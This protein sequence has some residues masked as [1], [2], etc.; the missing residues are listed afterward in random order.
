MRR[1]CLSGA[2]VIAV[3]CGPEP[4]EHG[5]VS[6]ILRNATAKQATFYVSGGGREASGE[7]YETHWL[8]AGH[9]V[10]LPEAMAGPRGAR[11]VLGALVVAEGLHRRE[12]LGEVV[13]AAAHQLCTLTL[14]EGEGVA[15]ITQ[16][17]Q[18]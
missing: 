16:D 10:Q 18:R 15:V 4:T 8:P 12:Y 11:L 2:I 9:V 5:S 17:C 13:A 7:F 6:V 3:A 1:L 14:S